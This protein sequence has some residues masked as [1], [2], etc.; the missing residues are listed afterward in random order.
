MG[1]YWMLFSL[2]ELAAERGVGPAWLGLWLPNAIVL[3][4]SIWLVRRI[5][6]TDS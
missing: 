1:A 2:G 4:L 5:A 3:A 6:R